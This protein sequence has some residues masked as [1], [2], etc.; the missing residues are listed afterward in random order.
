MN[1]KHVFVMVGTIAAGLWSPMVMA[2]PTNE[3]YSTPM[4]Q[5]TLE[6]INSSPVVIEK[7][8]SSPVVIEKDCSSP[9][10]ID[11]TISAPVVLEKTGSPPVLLE[12]RIIKQKHFFGV[13][14]WP[15]FDFEIM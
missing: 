14:I 9:V 10:L 1:S 4:T 5:T 8:C 6:V 13:G 15:L 12:D 2:S 3:Y 11:T 7:N